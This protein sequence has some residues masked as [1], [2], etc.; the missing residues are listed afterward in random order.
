MRLSGAGRSE[1]DRLLANGLPHTKAP[2]KGAEYRIP[3]G[4]ALRWLLDRLKLDPEG[5]TS[6]LSS[7]RA[8]LAVAQE[9]LTRVRLDRERGLLVPAAE[10]RATREAE[11]AAFRDRIRSVPAA[12]AE[13]V[14]DAAKMGAKGPEIAATLLHEIDSALED[15]ANAEVILLSPG[16]E[17]DAPPR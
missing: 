13:R 10:V 16:D 7:A 12:L 4:P 11:N 3:Q 9:E 14:I 2:G 15:M 1:V 5:A 17:D 6:D 8:R